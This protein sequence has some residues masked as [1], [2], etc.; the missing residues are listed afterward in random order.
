MLIEE[1]KK[2][3]N[4]SGTGR[5]QE[6]VKPSIYRLYKEYL[7][8]GQYPYIETVAV[9]IE[10]Q[11]EP[12]QLDEALK[13]NLRTEVYICSRQHE[14]E[15]E[16]EKQSALVQQG[17]QPFTVEAVLNAGTRRLELIISGQNLL[18]FNVESKKILRPLITKEGRAALMPKGARTKGFFAEQFIGRAMFRYI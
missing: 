7:A 18:G 12:I 11:L 1:I 4:Y 14:K 8:T 9:W 6:P 3:V 13:R 16:E 10:K 17:Y 2:H 5:Y 15:Q